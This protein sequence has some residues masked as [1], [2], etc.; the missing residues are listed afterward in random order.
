MLFESQENVK[1][2]VELPDV[3]IILRKDICFSKLCYTYYRLVNYIFSDNLFLIY[4]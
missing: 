3:D 4:Y 1:V 2:L